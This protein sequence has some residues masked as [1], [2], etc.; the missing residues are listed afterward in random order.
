MNKLTGMM[1]DKQR[2]TYLHKLNDEQLILLPLDI[3]ISTLEIRDNIKKIIN[4]DT[5]TYATVCRGW[6][7]DNRQLQ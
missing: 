1:S 6:E 4:F 3:V 2:I 5:T 7:W